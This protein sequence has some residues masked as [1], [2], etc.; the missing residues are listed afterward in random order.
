[1][2]VKIYKV[3]MFSV[4]LSSMHWFVGSKVEAGCVPTA[5]SK[6]EAKYLLNFVPQV[7]LFLRDGRRVEKL[8]WSKK[9][10]SNSRGSYYFLVLTSDKEHTP[11]EN[12]LIGYFNVNE[13]TAEVS[14]VNGETISD[15]ILASRQAELRKRHC[16]LG[17]EGS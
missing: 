14:D 16:L 8:E 5:I 10:I 4:L 17:I 13:R 6:T 15:V 11:L 7:E 3:T 12:G 1:M 2:F 9:P